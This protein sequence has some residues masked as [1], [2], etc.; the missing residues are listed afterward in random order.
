[1]SGCAYCGADALALDIMP[2]AVAGG[3]AKTADCVMCGR[4]QIRLQTGRG[5]FVMP[6]P[7]TPHAV[8]ALAAYLPGWD[9]L[10]QHDR[11]TVSMIVAGLA[12]QRAQPEN[13][14]D[15]SQP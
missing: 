3:R 8:T 7:G 14:T 1:M 11:E 10:T 6:E 12:E 2:D 9:R 4:R 15:D 5:D 13:L